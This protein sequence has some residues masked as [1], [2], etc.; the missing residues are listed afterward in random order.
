MAFLKADW[1][2]MGCCAMHLLMCTLYTEIRLS[3]DLIA[4]LIPVSFSGELYLSGKNVNGHRQNI[5]QMFLDKQHCSLISLDLSMRKALQCLQCWLFY[6]YP[7]PEISDSRNTADICR[8]NMHT[9][10]WQ[11]RI[12]ML[13]AWRCWIHRSSQFTRVHINNFFKINNSVCAKS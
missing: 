1:F 12:D 9:V 3:T 4:I 11:S 5:L 10:A 13:P 8:N 2:Q 7:Q 6:H